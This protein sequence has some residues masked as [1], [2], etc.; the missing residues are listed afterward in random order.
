M[1]DIIQKYYKTG[2]IIL[3]KEIDKKY[4]PDIAFYSIRNKSELFSDKQDYFRQLIPTLNYSWLQL[5]LD[6]FVMLD[7]D[8]VLD[9]YHDNVELHH[10]KLPLSQRNE[11]FSRIEDV[12]Q[13][14]EKELYPNGRPKKEK[15]KLLAKEND[16][17]ARITP[18]AFTFKIRL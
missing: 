6:L 8:L 9:I 12:A 1:N 16:A 15:N 17:E 2:D 18:E 10:L 13:Q 14:R 5:R 4:Y 7:I 3:L 11:L